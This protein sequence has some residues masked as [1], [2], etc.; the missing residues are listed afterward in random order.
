MGAILL[1]LPLLAF[2]GNH[3]LHLFEVPD[4]EGAQAGVDVLQAM[5]DGGLMAPIAASHVVIGALLL[6]PATR[7]AAG[8]LQLPMSVGIVAFHV[9][10][11]PEGT[12]PGVVMLV[13][14]AMVVADPARLRALLSR[15]TRRA[16]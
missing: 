12:G 2:G 9:T 13:L 11:L 1:A 14:N 5:R 4:P 8:L 15:P 10:M 16:A 6:V 3:F 7:F